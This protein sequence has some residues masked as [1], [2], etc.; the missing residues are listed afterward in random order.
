MGIDEVG[1]DKVGINRDAD[2]CG[3]SQREQHTVGFNISDSGS[4]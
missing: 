2:Y 1:I 4:L 3:K